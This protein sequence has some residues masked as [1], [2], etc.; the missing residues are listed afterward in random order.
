MIDAPFSLEPWRYSKG[1]VLYT[2]SRVVI[3][4][5]YLSVFSVLQPHLGR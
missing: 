1:W 4:V 3:I 5:A 2:F